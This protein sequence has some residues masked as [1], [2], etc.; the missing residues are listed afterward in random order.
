M[1]D[2][3]YRTSTRE[4]VPLPFYRKGGREGFAQVTYS[5]RIWIPDT[6]Y[7]RSVK[8]DWQCRPALAS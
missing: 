6:L 8:T 7:A 2:W 3:A 4:R 1:T 5:G